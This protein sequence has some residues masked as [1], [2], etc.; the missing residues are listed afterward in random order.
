MVV[1]SILGVF[2]HYLILDYLLNEIESEGLR[3]SA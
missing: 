1:G 2:M 3:V